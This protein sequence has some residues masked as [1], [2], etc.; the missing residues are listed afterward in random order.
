V[1]RTINE[2]LAAATRI[3]PLAP[4]LIDARSEETLTH[5]QL[6]ARLAEVRS[7]LRA[8]QIL[9]GDVVAIASGNS[10]EMAVTLLGIMSYGAIANPLNPTLVEPEVRS[11]LEHSGA[12]LLL[13]DDT[14]RYPGI[15]ARIVR[16]RPLRLQHQPSMSPPPGAEPREADG[17]LLIYTSGTTGKPKGVLLS[18]RN[19]VVNATVASTSLRLEPGHRSL[20]IL[21][22][23]H[24]FA[25]ISD[26][27]AVLFVGGC[28]VIEAVFDATGL[29]QLAR[30][31]EVFAI[32][33]FSAVP[34]MFDLLV[35]FEVPLRS[36]HLRFCVAGA[37]PLRPETMAAFEAHS[38]APIIPAYGMT[39]LTC[40]CTISPPSAIVPGSAGLPAGCQVRVVDERGT[41]VAVG[42]IGELVVHGPNVIEGGYF[43]D[44][45]PCYSDAAG[46]WLATGD[47]ARLDDAGYV[48]IVGR[49]KNMMIRGGEKIYLEDL[50]RAL[51]QLQGVADCASVGLVGGDVDRIFTF[52]VSDGQRD[53]SHTDVLHF[54]RAAVGAAK[55]PDK[56][57]FVGAIPRTATNKVR[58]EQLQ[59]W[60]HSA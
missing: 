40:F 58:L 38:G 3:D 16:R 31:A 27:C 6:A 37:A 18:H 21:P 4:A 51:L 17:A 56:V 53:L 26:L 57:S 48:F 32:H 11:L 14:T 25:F 49:K 36:A 55:L 35:R 44:D 50:D 1:N 42:A 60:A 9:P 29:Q 24:T 7:A 47:L 5:A 19:L 33:S 8:E 59:Q 22:L 23:F 20:V 46:N 39:E 43:R 54:L 41:D 12:R 34:L 28:S 15:D 45:R 30:S 13:L 52:V 10:L 2:S